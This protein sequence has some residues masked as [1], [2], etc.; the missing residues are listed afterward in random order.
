MARLRGVLLTGLAL[1][2]PVFTRAQLPSNVNTAVQFVP[3]GNLDC[4]GFSAI[5]KPLRPQQRCTDIRGLNGARFE[6]NGHYIGHDEP[7]I[8]F[9]SSHPKSGNNLQWEFT[10]PVERPLPATQSFENFITF[11]FSG[12]ICDPNSYPQG[13]CIADSDA[14]DPA[15]AGSAVLELQFYP[16]GFSPFITQ[17]SCDLKHWCAALNIDSLECNLNFAFCNANCI[18]PINFAFVQTNGIPPGPPGPASATNATFTPN[19]QTFLM[20]Q[21]DR[22]RVTI[23]DT[24]QG[25][26]TLVEDLTTGRSGFMVASAANGFQN[27][28]LN[29]CK[30]KNFS[31]HPEFATAKV[32]NFVPWAALQINVNFAMELGHFTPGVNG[33]KDAD[34]APCFPGPTVAGCLDLV[35]GGDLDFD[36]SSYLFDWPDE[37]RKNATSVK[38]RSVEGGGIGPL[39]ASGEGGDVAYDRPYPKIQFETDVPASETACMPDGSGCVVPPAGALFY[40][41]YAVATQGEDDEDGGSC[42][43]LFGNFSGN[44][45]NN[46]GGDA[47]YGSSNVSWF[48]GTNSGGIRRNPCIP[49]QN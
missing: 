11:W 14:N 13:K 30:G 45:I 44:H 49:G 39:S 32:G 33:D 5:Q 43:L 37:T 26:L 18:E 9:Y 40:P 46:F 36:G 19:S 34:D 23:K 8:G 42:T 41:F 2:F 22:I 35:Q 20:N 27:T 1:V 4:N 24:P 29:S 28:D 17:I 25:L 47:Q 6:D 21:G 31:F 48:F 12:A 38:I 16:P 7:S 15:K 10:L 3:V